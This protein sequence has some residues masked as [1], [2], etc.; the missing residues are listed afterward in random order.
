M[1]PSG[2]ERL[3]APFGRPSLNRC[4][5]RPQFCAAG[6]I[7]DAIEPLARAIARS[8]PAVVSEGRSNDE[9]TAVFPGF[10]RPHMPAD[11]A[12]RHAEF[13]RG[14][15]HREVRA[16]VSN[17]RLACRGDRR[18]QDMALSITQR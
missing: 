12:R 3:E 11:G 5:N 13:L 16:A 9:G 17:A 18:R 8:S 6:L 10:Q 15:R 14:A 1:A 4:A 2:R 7:G